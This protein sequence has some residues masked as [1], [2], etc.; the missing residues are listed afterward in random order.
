[1]ELGLLIAVLVFQ[2]GLF[3]QIRWVGKSIESWSANLADVFDEM[4][5]EYQIMTKTF[6]LVAKN[7]QVYHYLPEDQH[8]YYGQQTE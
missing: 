7:R 5:R 2:F 6:A 1:M 3:L 4:A 8:D